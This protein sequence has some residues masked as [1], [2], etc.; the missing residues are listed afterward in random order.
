MNKQLNSKELRELMEA[1]RELGQLPRQRA[2]CRGEPDC[3][4]AIDER[5]AE[6]KAKIRRLEG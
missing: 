3:L 6:L 1:K 5:V 4:R 2:G